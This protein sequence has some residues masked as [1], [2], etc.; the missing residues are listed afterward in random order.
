MEPRIPSPT[1]YLRNKFRIE[2]GQNDAFFVGQEKLLTAA[3]PKLE[4][5]A[6]GGARSLVRSKKAPEPSPPMMHIWRC[7]EWSSL[8][9]VM[10]LLSDTDWY[11]AEVRSLVSEH[12]DLLVSVSTGYGTSRRPYWKDDDH[13]GHVYL[14]EEVRL[15]KEVTTHTYLR[16]LNWFAD[17]VVATHGWTRIWSALEVTGTPSQLCHLWA[18]PDVPAI[19]DAID[20]IANAPGSRDRYARMMGRIQHL[21][22]AYLHPESTERMDDTLFSPDPRPT[23]KGA[24]P[25]FVRDRGQEQT[26]VRL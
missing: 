9:E 19:D 13:A 3:R 1:I 15:R 24:S 18:A 16:D 12:Q 6:A 11:S 17:Q 7:K 8:Y 25:L 22:R 4:L 10:Y 21:S 26:D 23:T 5:V 20:T 2:P 14:Y